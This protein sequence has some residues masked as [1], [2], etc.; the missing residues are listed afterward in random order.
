MG[1]IH[2]R[3]IGVR[4]VQELQVNEGLSNEYIYTC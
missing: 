3:Y 4:A 2:T 1:I